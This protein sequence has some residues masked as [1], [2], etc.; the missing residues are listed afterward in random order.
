M[1]MGISGV[2][3][4]LKS[5][6]NT[7]TAPAFTFASNFNIVSMVML[8]L[9]QRIGIETILCICI[10]LPLLLLFSKMQTQTLTLSVNGPLHLAYCNTFLDAL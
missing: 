6:D 2:L 7:W 3:C 10:L 5:E 8:M 4:K 1:K 9:I